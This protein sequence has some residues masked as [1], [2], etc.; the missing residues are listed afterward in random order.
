MAC[1]LLKIDE[2]E[3]DDNDV[4]DKAPAGSKAEV[5]NLLGEDPIQDIEPSEKEVPIEEDGE[6]ITLSNDLTVTP[7]MAKTELETKDAELG[8]LKEMQ[9]SHSLDKKRETIL[10]NEVELEELNDQFNELVE[11]GDHEAALQVANTYAAKAKETSD[12]VDEYMM[13]RAEKLRGNNSVMDPEEISELGDYANRK[14]L[15]AREMV[16]TQQKAIAGAKAISNM[17]LQEAKVEDPDIFKASLLKAEDDHKSGNPEAAKI[18]RKIDDMNEMKALTKEPYYFEK[19]TSMPKLVEMKGT[20]ERKIRQDKSDKRVSEDTKSTDDAALRWV[21]NT[22]REKSNYDADQEL[23]SVNQE[24]QKLVQ[25]KARRLT[26]SDPKVQQQQAKKAATTAAKT[27]ETTT[28][29]RQKKEAADTGKKATLLQKRISAVQKQQPKTRKTPAT[30]VSEERTHELEQSKARKAAQKKQAE[31]V[32]KLDRKS[33]GLPKKVDVKDLQSD[34]SEYVI[35]TPD[36]PQSKTAPDWQNRRARL[37]LMKELD[38]LGIE[39]ELA[40]SYFED[41]VEKAFII[42]GMTKEE[43]KKLS[44]RLNQTSYMHGKGENLDL[45]EGDEVRRVKKKDAKVAQNPMAYT[46]IQGKKWAAPFYTEKESILDFESAQISKDEVVAAKSQF[47]SAAIKYKGKVYEGS[48][49]MQ[50]INSNDDLQEALISI[51]TWQIHSQ[52]DHGFVTHDGNF[53]DRMTAGK[54]LGLKEGNYL[55]SEAFLSPTLDLKAEQM[56]KDTGI[57]IPG[58]GDM[59]I[60][61]K[62]GT[63][64]VADLMKNE[65]ETG[66]YKWLFDRTK[67]LGVET[68]FVTAPGQYGKNETIKRFYPDLKSKDEAVRRFE[69]GLNV[70]PRTGQ[71]KHAGGVKGVYIKADPMKGNFGGKAFINIPI[72]KSRK[73]SLKQAMETVVH[74]HL[75]GITDHA[76]RKMTPEQ[77]LAFKAELESVWAS[78]PKEFVDETLEAD[79]THV[80]VGAGIIQIRRDGISELI[81]YAMAHPEFA[82][83]LDTIP[84]SPKFRAQSSTIKTMWDKLVHMITKLTK[85]TS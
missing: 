31:E 56:Q 3:D 15:R 20:L 8:M 44:D 72:I 45:I 36:N 37:K 13:H 79:D 29:Q 30:P 71:M 62:M 21:N 38:D 16:A 73:P 41:D 83:W 65:M 17:E 11:R 66:E 61:Q 27:Q 6:G 77:K 75:H 64:E 19:V 34:K 46:M 55:Q 49:H 76:Q 23:I 51:P 68:V 1:T 12:S 58:F 67:E 32:A 60:D 78:I 52:F 42:K 2:W 24:R 9:L 70:D 25:E 54:Q 35:L 59:T 74:E 53:T 84:A 22:I 5:R 85:Q 4:R 50:I 48:S 14:N 82:A 43:G 39:Y 40:D 81:T 7:N 69:G 33:H 28:R 63:L 57:T 18:Y 80:R 10:V 47:R 26:S